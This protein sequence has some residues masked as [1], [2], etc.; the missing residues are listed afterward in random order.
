MR[1]IGISFSWKILT[2]VILLLH[3]SPFLS[4]QFNNN[5]CFKFIS[6]LPHP[7]S[8]NNFLISF[9]AL[10]HL[11]YNFIR[12]L[13][14]PDLMFRIKRTYVMQT[15]LRFNGRVVLLGPGDSVHPRAD[16]GW[17]PSY[18]MWCIVRWFSSSRWWMLLR[19]THRPRFRFGPPLR[20]A[21]KS[22]R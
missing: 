3:S 14:H 1:N 22:T 5:N 4:H 9:T 7:G 15:R 8:I 6:K 13:F 19:F 11:N 16:G 17:S 21:S 2:Y 20:S 18:K 10:Y 12:R